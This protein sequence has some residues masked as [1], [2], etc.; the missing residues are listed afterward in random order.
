MVGS[1]SNLKMPVRN[2]GYH[3]PL[4]IGGQKTTVLGG[5]RNL[6]ATL[7]AYIFGMKHDIDNRLSA[8]TTKRGLLYRP[9]MS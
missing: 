4:Q 3:L 7:T 1:K 5:L 9:E 2:L 8:L 6:T